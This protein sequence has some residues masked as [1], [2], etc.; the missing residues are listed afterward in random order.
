MPR[1]VEPRRSTVGEELRERG[2]E[3]W[4]ACDEAV[5]D[6]L[7]ESDAA[8]RIV[9]YHSARGLEGWATVAFGLDELYANK[10]KHPNLAPGEHASAEDVAK[11]WLM[12]ALTRAAHVLVVTVENEASPVAGWLRAAAARMPDDVVEWR[13]PCVKTSS[14]ATRS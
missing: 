9:Q 7:P 1:G 5:R 10:L 2:H 14:E 4:D 3:V 12:I 6:V 13:G 11:R 8:V